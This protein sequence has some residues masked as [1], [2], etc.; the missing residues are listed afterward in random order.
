MNDLKQDQLYRSLATLPNH[1]G[2]I[3]LLDMMEQLCERSETELLQ[4][5]AHETGKVSS[6]LNQAQAQRK[7]FERLQMEVNSAV[8]YSVTTPII[9]F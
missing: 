8:N 1:P 6:L 7:F 5:P 4:C 2:Y 9:T 3:A